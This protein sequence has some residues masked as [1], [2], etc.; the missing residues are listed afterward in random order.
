MSCFVAWLRSSPPQYRLAASL[1][2]FCWMIL[3]SVAGEPQK[4]SATPPDSVLLP[5]VAPRETEYDNY[6]KPVSGERVVLPL[7][8]PEQPQ[9]VKLSG[10]SEMVTL[11]ANGAELTSVLKMIAEH[12]DLNLVIGPDV[13]GPVTVSLRDARLD[14]VLDAI[15]GVA[16]Y[17]WHQV[18]NLLYVTGASSQGMDPRVQGRTVQVYSLDY[19]SAVDV[20][21]VANSLLSPVGNA[22]VSESEVD[23]QKR[24]REVL[25]V[26]DTARAHARVASYIA[27]IDVPP[28]QVLVE[29]HVLQ[30]SLDEEN[31]HGINLEGLARLDG[32][33]ISIEGTGF[34]GDDGG[35]NLALRVNGSDM[36][37]LIDLIRK[38]TNSRTLA[39]PKLSVINSQEATIQIGQRLPY[40]V[41]TTTQ[42]TTV[43]SVEFLVVGIVLRV[44]PVITDDGNV[45]LTVSPKVSGGK[46]TE[47]GFPEEETTELTT[48]VMMRDGGGI[49]IGGLIRED[50]VQTSA[51]V[52]GFSRVPVLGH[53][54]KK[55]AHE[56]RRNELVIA[57]V[58]HVIDDACGQRAHEIIELENTLPPYAAGQLGSPM[59]IGSEIIDDPNGVIVQ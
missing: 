19:V 41:A 50:D 34:N 14:E 4:A 42:T 16:G 24:T 46:I 37:A 47:S 36:D 58:T 32:S 31:R 22:F 38:N 2:V 52:P 9:D 30:I 56:T 48:T 33:S 43:Q 12:H 13:H 10:G 1:A 7:A 21:P 39:S 44:E 11:V 49:V 53:L 35:P 3:L 27:Q 15:L 5:F 40:A 29:A 20:E 8:K 51:A 57:L 54:F 59:M 26:E 28:R 55:R 25:I 45:L 17:A 6:V 18:D 23:N